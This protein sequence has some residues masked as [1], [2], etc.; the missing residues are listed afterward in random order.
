MPQAISYIRFS[1]AQ[2]GAG[3]TTERQQAMVSE[4]LNRHP[5]VHLSALSQQDLGRSG[6][7]GDHLKHGL[8]RILDAIDVGKINAGDFILVEAIDRLGRLDAMDMVSLVNSIASKGVIIVTLEDQ[9]TYSKEVIQSN[10]S[11]IY[12]LVGKAQQA[13]EYSRNLSRRISASYESK[14][15]KARAGQ[16]IKKSTPF[17][18]NTSGALIPERAEAIKSCISMY[19][20]GHGPRNILQTLI[21]SHPVLKKTHPSTLKRWLKSRALIG[22]WENKGDPIKE[23]YE[24]LIDTNTFYKIQRSLNS[25]S[26][27]MSPDQQYLLSGLVR[28]GSCRKRLYYRTRDY[29]GKKIIYA[30]CSTYLRRGKLFCDNNTT[31]PYEALMNIFNVTFIEHL[32]RAAWDQTKSNL[33]TELDTING[34]INEIDTQIK[35]VLETGY[36]VLPDSQVVRDKLSTLAEQRKPLETRAHAIQAELSVDQVSNVKTLE[37][38]AVDGNEFISIALQDDTRLRTILS[39]TSY[40]IEMI[41]KVAT[42]PIE[43]GSDK[44]HKFELT[45]RSQRHKCYIIKQTIPEFETEIIDLDQGG[46]RDTVTV[47]SEITWRAVN[48]DGILAESASENELMAELEKVK[49][50]EN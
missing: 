7:S 9:Q 12:V 32:G 35:F 8:G 45:K 33:A 6:F 28:C 16:G 13:N 39:K 22:E 26:L 23:V 29:N 43:F 14:R 46:V 27:S 31:W 49:S 21:P 34:E 2:Q 17:W 47:D 30:N 37:A 4:W 41:G 20:D 36:S 3:S 10:S 25:R 11:L 48:R 19:L 40:Q 50:R 5:D 18:L 38:M 42:I 24:P 15:R 1:S 44:L